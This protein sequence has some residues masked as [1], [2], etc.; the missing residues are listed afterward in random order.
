MKPPT[1][2]G[3][4]VPKRVDHAQRRAHITDALVRVAARDGLHS[5]TLRA[6]AAEA[7]MSLNLVQYYFDTKAQLLHAALERLEQLS[8]ER[9]SARL[10]GLPSPPTAPAVIEALLAEALPTDAPSRAFHLVWTAYAVLAMNDAEL[11]AQPF[12]EGPNRLE[13]HLT[14]AFR[15]A[16]RAGIADARRDPAA[17][18][19]HLLCLS[20]GLGTSV[21]VGQRTAD[22]AADIL[23]RHLDQL[24]PC[25][26][27]DET[28]TG[29]GARGAE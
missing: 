7:G 16:Q 14:D 6:V 11:A 8:R 3:A 15:Q 10:A 2:R 25:A 17:E 24:F 4:H 21:L 1:G 9:W 13:R 22:A 18:A 5:V 12:V 20:H 19:A 29:S 28:G 23:R 26:A 27:R